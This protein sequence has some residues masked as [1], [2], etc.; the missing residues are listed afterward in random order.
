MDSDSSFYLTLP[1]N[2]SDATFIAN[3]PQSYRVQLARP[4]VLDGRWE[5]ALTERQYPHNWVTFDEEMI[6]HL[7][8]PRVD[9]KGETKDADILFKLND[10]NLLTERARS[11]DQLIIHLPAGYYANA[12]DIFDKMIESAKVRYDS[13]NKDVYTEFPLSYKI[14]TNS[15]KAELNCSIKGAMLYR[16][17]GT[18]ILTAIG[19]YHTDK[20][21][22]WNNSYKFPVKSVTPFS[23]HQPALYVY[24][25]LVRHQLV[26]PSL[27]PLLRIVP[28]TGKLGDNI[29]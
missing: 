17:I 6:L 27:V 3:K 11:A 29:C 21:K 20:P 1:S 23:V 22:A 15:Q 8:I 9:N 19:I 16:K 18:D 13:L 28:T 24:S 10:T 7:N 26:G 5:V 14:N 2:S 12:E 4:L 25:D